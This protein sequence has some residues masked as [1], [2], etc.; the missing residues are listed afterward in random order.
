M[1][2]APKH[3]FA[4][5]VLLLLTLAFSTASLYEA[6]Q[7]RK[8][9]NYAGTEAHHAH[10]WAKATGQKVEADAPLDDSLW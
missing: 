1:M 3:L 5:Y 10:D 9:A 8:E 2:L 6:L 7:A 4:L